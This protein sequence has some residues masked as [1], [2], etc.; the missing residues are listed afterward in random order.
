MHFVS[1]QLEMPLQKDHAYTLRIEQTPSIGTPVRL[2]WRHVIADPL[3]DAV[4]AAKDA[5]VVIAVVGAVFWL[6]NR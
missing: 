2:I 1:A 6:F 5:D 4:K 3:G